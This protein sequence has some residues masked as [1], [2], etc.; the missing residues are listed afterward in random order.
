MLSFTAHLKCPDMDE[1]SFQVI[2]LIKRKQ[3][4][5][6]GKHLNLKIFCKNTKYYSYY[7]K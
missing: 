6:A 3:M 5:H 2:F 1:R 7:L 4:S